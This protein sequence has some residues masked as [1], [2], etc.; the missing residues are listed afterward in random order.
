MNDT[1]RAIAKMQSLQSLLDNNGEHEPALSGADSVDLHRL[2][3][4]DAVRTRSKS[5]SADANCA[6]AAKQNTKGVRVERMVRDSFLDGVT[7]A[8]A[9]VGAFDAATIYEE[10]LATVGGRALR[11]R[12]RQTEATEWASL[13]K[14]RERRVP[15]VPS[16]PTAP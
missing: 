1:D 16:S 2:K 3:L 14:Y 13:D 8:L 5:K 7:A 10:I 4:T 9:V 11:R 6:R 12:A 15:N